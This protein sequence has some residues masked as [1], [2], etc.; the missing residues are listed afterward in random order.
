MRS[1]RR[2]TAFSAAA[3]LSATAAFS[4]TAASLFLAG[5]GNVATTTTPGLVTA[6]RQVG[7]NVH[8]GQQPVSGAT[9]QLW[10]VGATK[11]GDVSTPLL[12]TTVPVT[13]DA[14]GNFTLPAF[15][16][17][18][19]SSLIYMTATGG[20]P[21]LMG[22]VNNPGLAEMAAIG[23]CSQVQVPATVI[24]NE[25]TTA[26]AVFSLAPYMTS[27]SAVGS[28]PS[29][30][31]ALATAFTLS[32]SFVNF[33]TGQAPG[34]MLPVDAVDPVAALNTLANIAAVCVNTDG[35]AGSLCTSLYQ[36]APA[37]N[38]GLP[39]NTIG[40]LLNIAL[41]PTLNTTPLY[42]LTASFAPFQP[43]ATAPPPSFTPVLTTRGSVV[44][45]PANIVFPDTAYNA[46]SSQ[47]ITLT[48][49][50]TSPAYVTDALSSG[51][52]NFAVGGGSCG[53]LIY[54]GASCNMLA[55]FTPTSTG[56]LSATYTFGSSTSS[57]HPVLN[58]QGNGLAP[59]PGTL[60][61]S[62]ST[63]WIMTYPYSSGNA[64]ATV[65]LHNYSSYD[66]TIG[67]IQFGNQYANNFTQTNDCP[68]V[69]L[70]QAYCTIT[71]TA[72]RYPPSVISGTYQTN[73]LQVFDSAASSPQTISLTANIHEQISQLAYNLGV[74]PS[75]LTFE[76]DWLYGYP[77]FSLSGPDAKDFSVSVTG[78]YSPGLCFV[79]GDYNFC[80]VIVSFT[81]T[82]T[83]TETAYLYT[84]NHTITLT[85]QSP[86]S[87]VTTL[88]VLTVDSASITDHGTLH[89]ANVSSS[90]QPV[91]LTYG[92]PG[93]AN[94]V[95][96]L[97]SLAPGATT[98]VS[99]DLTTLPLAA[100]TTLTITDPTAPHVITLSQT[101]SNYPSPVIT[102]TTNQYPATHIGATS[103]MYFPV[104]NPFGDPISLS[105]GN[106]SGATDFA[107]LGPPSCAANATSCGATVT[108]TPTA[109]GQRNGSFIATDL[110]TGLYYALSLSGTGG[111]A[112]YSP[113]TSSYDFGTKVIGTKSTAVFTVTNT[114]DGSGVCPASISESVNDY[115]ITSQSIPLAPGASCSVT[116]QFLP[117]GTGTR[118]GT[119]LSDTGALISLTGVGTY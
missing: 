8:G 98:S 79:N 22:T 81:P 86:V 39:S 26:A 65:Q 66:V 118:S 23:P 19:P 116:I 114:G 76:S 101:K 89:I 33:A 9:L 40:A 27:L 82:G 106:L 36:D 93:R 25:L 96:T 64:T 5:C 29:D 13:T 109:I 1:L 97:P 37:P 74:G 42:Q 88:G 61:F 48:N 75:T 84:G 51:S 58:L 50:S 54:A 31:A 35:S 56:P 45:T 41:Q 92:A 99:V 47:T 102:W 34:P 14:N 80:K 30:A 59:T 52:S 60:S 20:N 32:Q 111:I 70:S 107:L 115:T 6:A 24:I 73:T 2:S 69:L 28:S 7:G 68:A 110:V 78:G 90:S 53:S 46:T 71:V 119:L 3:T 63:V 4:V 113:S 112:A 104:T 103:A 17:P 11:D 49:T 44:V 12:S 91:T 87:T 18:S 16:C 10:V 100:F 72:M 108:F 15:T 105:V 55:T 77:N 95:S 57:V 67:A 117:S 62:P 94:S 43:Q 21:G 83:N 38:G 85:G